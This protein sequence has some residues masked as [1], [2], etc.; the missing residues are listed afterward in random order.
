MAESAGSRFAGFPPEAFEF[1]E[2]LELENSKRYFTARRAT[3]DG[4]VRGPLEAMLEELAAPV[5]GTVKMTRQ[6]R[7][8]RFSAD[9]SP[10]K[11]RTYGVIAD[12]QG[13][14][15]PLYAQ[16]SRAGLFAG[17]GYYGLARDQLARFR[18]A[19]L[20]PVPGAR[21]ERAVADAHAAGIET[22][23]QTLR[24]APRGISRE[25]PRIALLRH[26]LLIA[27]ATREPKQTG[28]S[29]QAA[30]DHARRV[31]SAAAPVADWLDANV[32]PSEDPPVSRDRGRRS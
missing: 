21:L 13:G 11:T 16:L 28:I 20:D 9:K 26:T 19:V 3:Y 10:Y 6:N 2:G 15:A 32:G 27:G 22:W 12:R 14:T 1:F 30:L 29:R 4:A 23:G 8:V 18:D 25:H 7:D 24:T 31:W 17:S 5:G